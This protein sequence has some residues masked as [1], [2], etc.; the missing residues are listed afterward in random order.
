MVY[1]CLCACELPDT[2]TVFAQFNGAGRSMDCT[3]CTD[4]S[5]FVNHIRAGKIA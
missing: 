1:V 4:V 3:H 2:S 5:D